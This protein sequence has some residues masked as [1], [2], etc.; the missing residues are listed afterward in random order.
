MIGSRGDSL[1]C[2]KSLT[3]SWYIKWRV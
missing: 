2:W 3:F 1:T